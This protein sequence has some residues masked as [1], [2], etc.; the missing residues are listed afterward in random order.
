M[1]G[2]FWRKPK[3]V[4]LK[5][6]S[7]VTLR[8]SQ[9]GDL[10]LAWDMFS[11]LSE[12]T[13]EFLPIPFNKE[14]VEEWFKGIDYSKAL[15]ILGFVDEESEPRMVVSTTLGFNSLELYSHRA[16]FGITVHDDYQDR[17]LGTILTG[18]MIGIAH[19]RGIK[20]LDLMVVAHNARA[21]NV[22]KKLGFEVEGH[23]RM[24]HFNHILKE[25]CDE[26]KMGLVLD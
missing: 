20:K 18:Y 22:Y 24:N 21:I 16:E 4:T 12:E 26:Y 1:N 11:T 17:G 23:F 25:Y 3:T 19:E 2:P 5:D 9:V 6:G 14:R 10:E 15:P 7:S 13:L 8:P